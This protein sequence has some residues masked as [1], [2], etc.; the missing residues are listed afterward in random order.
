[1][2]EIRTSTQAARPTYIVR[3][4]A[5]AGIDAVKALR[6]SLKI[7]GRRFGLQALSV[8]EERKS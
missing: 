3:L 8:R 5:K 7:L 2:T 4:R 1:M 6:S